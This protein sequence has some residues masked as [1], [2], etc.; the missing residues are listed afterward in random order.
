M[1][2][3]D[4]PAPDEHE[5]SG[6]ASEQPEPELAAHQEAF[7]RNRREVLHQRT[8]L[9]EL[10]ATVAATEER[11]AATFGALADRAEREGRADD[12]R[13]LATEAHAAL[14]AAEHERQQVRRWSKPTAWEDHPAD[15]AHERQEEGGSGGA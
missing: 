15:A 1:D 6:R 4:Q 7:E 3:A 14:R 8:Q 9:C 2:S 13:R 5:P 12:A 11:L 10:A